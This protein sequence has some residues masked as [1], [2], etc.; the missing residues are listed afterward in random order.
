M[1]QVGRWRLLI[2]DLNIQNAGMQV[3][4]IEVIGGNSDTCRDII[5]CVPRHTPV[6]YNDLFILLRIYASSLSV[7][8]LTSK[9]RSTW[10]LLLIGSSH[11]HDVLPPFLSDFSIIGENCTFFAQSANLINIAQPCGEFSRET[12][13][14]SK[15]SQTRWLLLLADDQVV[16]RGVPLEDLRAGPQQPLETGG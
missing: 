12:H 10:F 11:R 3:Q 4:R 9:S 14:L 16:L 1:S 2:Q 5:M 8:A 7:S 13:L 15:Y 6:L